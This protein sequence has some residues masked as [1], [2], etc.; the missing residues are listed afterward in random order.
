M[1]SFNPKKFTDPDWLATISPGRLVSL[2]RPWTA[3]LERRGFQF[4]KAGA[5]ELHCPTVASILMAPD[6]ST[7]PDMVDALYF[8]QET[9]SVEDMEALL[10][11]AASHGLTL[12][13]DPQ[14]TPADVAIELWTSQPALLKAHHAEAL[15]CRQQ[16]FDYFG[17]TRRPRPFPD[18][19]EATRLLIEAELDDWFEARRRGRGSRLLI[20]RHGSLV[21]LL[22]R[23]G[24]VMRREASHGDDGSAGAAF[25][26]PQQHDVLVYDE[27]TNEIG[28]HASTLGEKRLYL[29]TIGAHLFQ[30]AGYFPSSPR[31]TLA[32]LADD[33]PDALVCEDIPGIDAIR[34][35]EYRLF[36][37]G[38]YKEQE[39]RRATDIYAAAAARGIERP[40]PMEPTA[41]VFKVRFTDSTRER[42]VTIRKPA[43][44]R[45]ER[46]G[47]GAV[48]ETWLRARGL[49]LRTGA[50]ELPD[51]DAA[52]LLESA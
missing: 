25:Y 41:A 18:I 29:R 6:A 22:V 36:W 47:D 21:W 1:S 5:A 26:R 37:G 15:A 43:S 12:D 45:Y 19:D 24:H 32:P 28:V 13:D 23:H 34:L 10:E 51:A 38:A 11:I 42:K 20:F 17:G 35:I 30:D 2:L 40:I 7:P 49:L 44:A 14:V 39:V 50:T 33:G 48:I 31:F 16:S 46:D 4:P 27:R 52:A 3:Y 8:I 9:S